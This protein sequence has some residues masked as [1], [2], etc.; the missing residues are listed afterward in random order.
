MKSRLV[1]LVAVLQAGYGLLLRL[2]P[3]SFREE[4]AHEM[5]SVFG[6][7]LADAA[8]RGP[9]AATGAYVRTLLRAGAL[10]KGG[11]GP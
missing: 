10:R 9:A 4:F 1:F 6:A 7:T 8:A 5:R 2:Y 11:R 3:R